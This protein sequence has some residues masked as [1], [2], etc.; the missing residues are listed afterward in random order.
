M[1]T[2]KLVHFCQA[3]FTSFSQHGGVAGNRTDKAARKNQK[4]ESD[5][6]QNTTLSGDMI[7][8]CGFVATS[9]TFHRT[10]SL[11]KKKFVS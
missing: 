7:S 10:H 2:T 1:K 8:L 11:N 4:H 9:N 3:V 6:A 5:S